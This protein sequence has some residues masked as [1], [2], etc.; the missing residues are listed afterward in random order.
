MCNRNLHICIRICIF[1]PLHI[2]IFATGKQVYHGG[3]RGL[4]IST[5]FHFYGS[6]KAIK[7]AQKQNNKD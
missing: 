2:D 3:E 4:E 5:I 6:K 7:L 1:V